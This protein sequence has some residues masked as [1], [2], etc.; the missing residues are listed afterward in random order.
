M[1]RFCRGLNFWYLIRAYLLSGAFLNHLKDVVFLLHWRSR[2]LVVQRRPGACPAAPGPS[3]AW[4]L[5][6]VPYWPSLMG[7]NGPIFLFLRHL[8]R[9]GQP[10]QAV[11]GDGC[12]V[13]AVGK[14]DGG[15]LLQH[16]L[17]GDFQLAPELCL[18][19]L[20]SGL[21]F[22]LFSTAVGPCCT[23][24]FRCTRPALR[25]RWH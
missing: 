23:L 14:G 12:K 2:L 10:D 5:I 3:P 1:A 4:S 6:S 22:Q 21:E 16:P 20:D 19:L 24:S 8:I 7:G 15:Q 9:G 17:L 25:R 18:A 13:G 11:V